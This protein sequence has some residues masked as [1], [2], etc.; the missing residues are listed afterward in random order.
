MYEEDSDDTD[1]DILKDPAIYG[2][3]LT[4]YTDDSRTEEGE[5]LL[6]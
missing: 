4:Y 1:T 3:M 2:L 5:I 6:Q